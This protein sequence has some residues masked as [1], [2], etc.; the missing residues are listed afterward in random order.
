MSLPGGGRGVFLGS[1]ELA[2]VDFEVGGADFPV[3]MFSRFAA[4]VIALRHMVGEACLQPPANGGSGCVIVD[5]PLL[6]S[7]YGHLDIQTLPEFTSRHHFHLTIAFIPHSWWTSARR[8]VDLFR[9][10][11]ERLSICFHGNDHTGAEFA[12]MDESFLNY[13]LRTARERMRKHSEKFQLACSRV[14]VFPQGNFSMQAMEALSAHGFL[15]AVNTVPYPREAPGTK[16]T[17]G[18]VAAPAVMR[19]GRYPLFLRKPAKAWTEFDVAACLFFGR[20]ILVVEHH[21]IGRE[22]ETLARFAELVNT[23]APGIQWR[24]LEQV[25][26]GSYLTQ[27][28]AGG[29]RITRR[30]VNENVPLPNE[31]LPMRTPGMGWRMKAFL[32]RRLSELRDN[33]LSRSPG[34]LRFAKSVQKRLWR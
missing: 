5:D 31:Q 25:V 14:M 12:S 13:A 8:I 7:R 28:T 19:Y 18:D 27:V 1:A 16:L 23:V 30:Y 11:P 34:F 4:Y 3:E 15:A 10:H 6:R 22:M 33:Y 29:E 26:K 21:E 2:D 32:R 9:S 20:P 17:L 24:D